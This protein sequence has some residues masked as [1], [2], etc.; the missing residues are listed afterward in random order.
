MSNTAERRAAI[1]RA[2]VR[3]SDA[4]MVVT[5]ACLHV[6]GGLAHTDAHDIAL[7]QHKAMVMAPLYGSPSAHRARFPGVA[8]E[9]SD[10]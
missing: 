6:H 4:A 1:S 7:F 9:S 2:K 8:L 10:G 3:V 5:R